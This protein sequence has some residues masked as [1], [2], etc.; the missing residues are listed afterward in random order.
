MDPWPPP[1][2]GPGRAKRTTRSSRRQFRLSQLS[3]MPAEDVTKVL[4]MIVDIALTLTT[5]EAAS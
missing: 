2:V 4:D 5:T 1:G 3:G